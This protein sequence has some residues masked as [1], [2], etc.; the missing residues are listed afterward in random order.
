MNTKKQYF[1][2]WQQ[3]R[4]NTGFGVNDFLFAS[5]A[6]LYATKEQDRTVTRTVYL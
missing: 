4:E 5:F 3:P 6:N 2:E 1:H